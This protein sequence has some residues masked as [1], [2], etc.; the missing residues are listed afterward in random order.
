MSTKPKPA[1]TAETR[2]KMATAKRGVTRSTESRA[3]QGASISGT[4]HWAAKVWILLSPT[5]E[6]VRTAE[7]N[8]FCVAHG[9]N[10]YSLRNRANF[11]DQRPITRG[12][13]AG[14]SVLACRRHELVISVD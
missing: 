1:L 12:P 5:G 3:K 9:L 14:W 11:N 7:M 8:N 4:A 13:S 2:E 6:L 10:Y